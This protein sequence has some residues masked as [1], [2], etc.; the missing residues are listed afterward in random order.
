MVKRLDIMLLGGLGFIV[1]G[2]P[3]EKLP[4]R[5]G[6]ALLIY[7]AY[8][9]LPIPRSEL[10]H[11]FFRNTTPSQARANLR[12]TLSR[13]KKRVGDVFAANRQ[14]VWMRAEVAVV[15]DGLAFSHQLSKS[16]NDRSPNTQHSLQKTLAL[17]KGNFL[18]GFHLRAAPEFEEWMISEREQ[19][20]LL[21]I[22]GYSQLV[23]L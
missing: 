8:Q 20:R 22:E 5:V 12:G 9:P 16:P 10:A 21:A 6:Q 1:D 14:Q 18:S 15:V 2:K 11:L 3:I 13:I 23:G 7:L 4:N 19:L 17:Y